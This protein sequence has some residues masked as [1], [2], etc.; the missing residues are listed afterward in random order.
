MPSLSPKSEASALLRNLK[1]RID[2]LAALAA[3]KQ[4]AEYGDP[5][6]HAEQAQL[7]LQGLN[8]IINNELQ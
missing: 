3:G 8:T 5:E 7:D 4:R 6:V 1:N 2:S